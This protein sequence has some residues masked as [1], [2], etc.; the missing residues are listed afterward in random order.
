MVRE[1]YEIVQSVGT[2][3]ER[4]SQIMPS[5][6]A[7][8]AHLGQVL[9]GNRIAPS[10]DPRRPDLAVKVHEPLDSSDPPIHPYPGSCSSVIPLYL[11][12]SSRTNQVQSSKRMENARLYQSGMSTKRPCLQLKWTLLPIGLGPC[13]FTPWWA[14][15]KCRDLSRHDQTSNMLP[16]IIV[17]LAWN[18]VQRS[19][20]ENLRMKTSVFAEKAFPRIGRSGCS[21]LSCSAKEYI[22]ALSRLA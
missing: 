10:R 21:R 18:P 19:A 22:L 12:R 16:S 14:E 17:S 20:F 8:A 2:A 5:S 7:A 15:T 9:G 3:R 1:A 6:T 11:L 13:H 4:L